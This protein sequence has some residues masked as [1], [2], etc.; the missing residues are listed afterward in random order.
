[1]PTLVTL[2]FDPLTYKLVHTIPV[3][4]CASFLS[5]LGFLGL[6]VLGLGGT[7]HTDGQTDGQTPAI[8]L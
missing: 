7:G 1:M 8:I 4:S 2:N 6:S 5:N 3:M